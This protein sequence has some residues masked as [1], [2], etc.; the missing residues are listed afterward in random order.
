[1]S[2][3]RTLR[4]GQLAVEL[5]GFDLRYLQAGDIEIVRRL[6]VA[7]RDVNWGTVPGMIEKMAV[8]E[9]RDNFLLACSVLHERG[10]I[11]FRWSGRFEGGA[12]GTL[13]Y[14]IAG[15][16]LSDFE[17]ARIGVCL[18]LPFEHFGG[19]S[20]DGEGPSGERLTGEFPTMIAPQVLD[21][22]GADGASFPP[23]R[24]LHVEAGDLEVDYRFLDEVF[25][26]EDQRN[27]T[28]ASFKFYCPPLGRLPLVGRNGD[29]VR[30]GV[31]IRV[32]SLSKRERPARNVVELTLGGD[33]SPVP[34]IG[35]SMPPAVALS[36]QVAGSLRGLHI[37]HVRAEIDA[38][39]QN[40]LRAV[41]R[42][43]RAASELGIPLE[44]VLLVGENWADELGRL[45]VLEKTDIPLTR[46]LVL[47]RN[48]FATDP[49][50]VSLARSFVPP[51]VAVGGGSN[52][53]FMELNLA[54]PDTT[55]FDVV[56]WGINS[57]VHAEDDLSLMESAYAHGETVRTARAITNGKPLAVTPVTL[58][59]RPAVDD[60]QPTQLA[61]AWTAMS[62]ASL[63]TGGV[64]SLTYFDAAGSG[65]LLNDEGRP[66]PL[67]DPL[68]FLAARTGAVSVAVHS[69]APLHVGAIGVRSANETEVLIANGRDVAQRVELRSNELRLAPFEVRV[70]SVPD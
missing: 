8:D 26:G 56:V 65:G 7:V 60:R 32:R 19:V 48:A 64:T 69:S 25:E 50:A 55:G 57:Q 18:L 47:P 16:C 67:A 62:L 24:R 14:A 3:V 13:S 70:V 15:E 6:T 30:N 37:A 52:R 66:Y 61:S 2:G 40:S 41:A 34:S 63:V 33:G 4:A 12:D 11:R 45:P 38:G 10:P 42:V 1:M 22:L 21:D 36:P 28:D 44:L 9:G 35:T 51:D 59:P 43:G 54:R 53:D 23:L 68:A 17:H 49:M 5:H 20:Y 58:K 39:A 46:L 31:E 27:W 29:T